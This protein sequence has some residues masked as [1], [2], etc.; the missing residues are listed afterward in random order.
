[1]MTIAPYGII[2][3]PLGVFEVHKKS[4]EGM[5]IGYLVAEKRFGIFNQ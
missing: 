5:G 1:M 4:N 2:F 3:I